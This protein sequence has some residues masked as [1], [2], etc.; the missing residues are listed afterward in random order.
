MD[1][2]VSCFAVIG[3]IGIDSPHG[4]KLLDM[5]VPIICYRRDLKI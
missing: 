5:S 4:K 3:D 2:E 1:H